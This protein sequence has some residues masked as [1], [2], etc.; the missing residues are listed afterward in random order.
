[1]DTLSNAAKK[2]W[3][4]PERVEKG[5][6]IPIMIT[7]SF[8]EPDIGKFKRLGMDVVVNA[9]W[10]A[11]FWAK[12]EGSRDAVTALEELIL[13]WPFDFI[14]IQGS[15]PEEIDENAFKWAI[16]MTAR[17]ERLRDFVGLANANLL[18]IV[19]RA[20]ELLQNQ[21]FAK[22]SPEK[23]Q[24]WLQQNVQWGLHHCPD[25]KTVKRHMDN[26]AA[27]Q[28]CPTVLD[29]IEAALNHWGRDNLLDWPTKLGKIVQKTNSSSICY[30]TE[31][32]YTR[33]WRMG[34]KDPYSVSA[35]D[36]IIAEILWARTYV[37]SF[38]RK[39]PEVFAGCNSV[40]G[41]FRFRII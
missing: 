21:V 9:V 25:A 7:S 8:S 13:D 27:I 2:P 4:I 32:L 12:Q 33:M 1:M 19:A 29:L 31:A 11:Y 28:K 10:L 20:A 41:Y 22:P 16:N 5:F 15:S 26:W 14:H 35:L 38:L 18:R 36:D 24:Q 34:M 40:R 3:Q 30:V 23:V 37:T 17:V 39:Y 6:E